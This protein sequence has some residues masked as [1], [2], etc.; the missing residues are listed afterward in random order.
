[1]LNFSISYPVLIKFPYFADI[2]EREDKGESR[3]DRGWNRG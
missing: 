1:M 3:G 2:T